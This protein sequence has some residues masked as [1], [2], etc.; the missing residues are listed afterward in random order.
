M[1]TPYQFLFVALL[2]LELELEE[3]LDD[4]SEELLLLDTFEL[5]V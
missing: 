4:P 2:P 1:S 5:L 3:E